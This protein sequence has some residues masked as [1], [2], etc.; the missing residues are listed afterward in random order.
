M[1]SCPSSRRGS[2][3]PAPP[4]RAL[5]AGRRR[6]DD[7][8]VYPVPDGD[9]GTNMVL[10]ARAGLEALEQAPPAATRAELARVLARG[11]LLGARGNSGVITSQ[12]LRGALDS[13]A[14]GGSLAGALAAAR[15]AGYSAV[16]EPVEGTILSMIRELADEAA[17]HADAGA[18]ELLP[19]LVRRGEDALARTPDQLP[20]LRRAGVVDAGAAGL[21][22]I[23]RG[24]AA[25]VAGEPLP[26]PADSEPLAL[27]A[28]HQ[29]L[30]RYRYCTV[31][32]VEG[33]DLDAGGLEQQL[34]ALGDSLLVVGDRTLLKV[35]VHTDDPGAALSAGAAIGVLERVEVA[36]MHRQTEAREER[37]LHERDGDDDARATD[38]VAVVAGTGNAE[39]FRSLGAARIVDGG[40]TMNPSAEQ[41][42][43]AIDA[44]SAP[45]A[46]VLPNNGNVILAAEQAAGLASKPARV[47][48]TR[49]LQEG[50]AALASSTT[51]PRPPGTTRPRWPRRPRPS[52]PA[53]SRSP[54]ARSIWPRAQCA[55]AS[56]SASW[57]A[58]PWRAGRASARSRPTSSIGCSPIPARC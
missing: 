46:L 36:N 37:L 12:I 7:L 15:D 23:V 45:E 9:T 29:E 32:A 10:T 25:A 28:V 1:R 8:N 31:F 56:T 49:S 58:S 50:L 5:E 14:A 18:G 53:P 40:R 43:A 20:I 26:A 6:L 42:L 55:P 22:E 19:A 17:A 24:L 13:L 51:A 57:P 16:R 52:A 41:I 21:L 30:S 2:T 34:A 11:T 48:P 39:L 47:L 27:D 35:H 3:S 33:D 38:V 54:R 44:T 4:R